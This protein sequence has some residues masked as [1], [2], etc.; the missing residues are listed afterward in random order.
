MQEAR[1]STDDDHA[2]DGESSAI[3]V[4]DIDIPSRF[5]LVTVVRMIIAS[6]SYA[7]DAVVG[8]RLDDLRWV[9]SEATTNAIQANLD[10]P[11]PGRVRVRAVVGPDW[12][13][14]RV[15][16]EGAGM[17]ESIA[18]PDMIDPERLDIEGGFGIPLMRTLSSS[19]VVFDV[20]GRR[21]RW[22]R[23]NSAADDRC[24]ATRQ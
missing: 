7:A 23:W 1:S 17:P 11:E 20:V 21:E 6:S 12:V 3:G 16:D 18:I 8:D 19:E 13:R 2:A 9:T 15:S 24:R 10:Q 14:L 5:D 22:S 4:V